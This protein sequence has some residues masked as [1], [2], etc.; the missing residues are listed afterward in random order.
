[1]DTQGLTASE[2]EPLTI[3]PERLYRMAPEVYR[4]MVEHG[5]LTDQG[6][7]EFR[8]GLLVKASNGEALADPLDHLYRIPLEVYHGIAD[9]GLLGP[10]DKVVL[11]D[12]LL[13][14]KMTRKP[15]HVTA[16]QRVVNA[17]GRVIPPGWYV[18]K[19]DP[20]A[21]P[22]GPAG[23]A[24]EPEPDVAVVRGG[25]DDYADRH[26][27]PAD[28]ALII[29]VADSSLREDREGLTGYAWANIPVV[30][31]V[32]LNG[33]VIEV[34]TLPTGP[35]RPARYQDLTTFGAADEVPVVIDGREV[36]RIPARDLLP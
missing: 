1:M 32:D 10:R 25:V 34:Y 8:D 12:G 19:E 27:G 16:T 21:L 24:S 33:K 28:V 2:L 9:H 6:G 5:L 7:V 15:P 20:L 30:W 17:L 18:R 23:R 13:V 4:G 31:V 29:E 11:L 36:G 22:A 14:K 35:A 3:L 26:P